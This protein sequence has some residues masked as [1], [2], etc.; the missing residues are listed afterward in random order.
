M[1]TAAARST[2][3]A[4]VRARLASVL[5]IM[6]LGIWTVVHLW[7]N[8]AAFDGGPA[9]QK[10]VTEY[11]HPFAQLVTLVIVLLPLAIH[12]VWGLGRIGTARPNNIRYGTFANLNYAL[13]RLSA[14]GVLF[15]LGAHLWLAM[16][17][18]RLVEGHAEVFADIAHEM[19]FHVPTLVVYVLGT[20]G[21]SY[22]LANGLQS[23]AMSWGVVV[24]RRALLRLRLGVVLAFVVFL[25]M[26]W[27]AIYA[28][29]TA[30]G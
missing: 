14:I 16:I 26:S 22:H 24:S 18:P 20:L 11:P 8:L 30:G 15:F 27:G 5:S 4:F 29:Y 21:V 3:P 6:P 2:A 1:A 12:L 10:A 7:H 17:S 28:L 9:W 19:R 13:Q 23:F 25:A